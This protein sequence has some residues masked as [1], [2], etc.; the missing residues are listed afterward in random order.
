MS[1]FYFQVLFYT[2]NLN[3]IQTGFEFGVIALGFSK[4]N[5]VKAH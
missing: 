1:F 5:K 4:P 2:S 3:E